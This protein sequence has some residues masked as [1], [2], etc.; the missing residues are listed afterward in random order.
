MSVVACVIIAVAVFLASCMQASIGFGMGMLAAPVVALVAPTLLP[1]MLIASATTV[2]LLVVI[3]ER[4]SL[5]LR[6]TGW[7]LI[8]RVPGTIAG[9]LLLVWLPTRGLSLLLAAV[10]LGGVAVASVGWRPAPGRRNLATAGAASGLLGTATSIGG[11]PMAL[12][13]S[14][15]ESAH[16]RSNMSAFFLAGSL[17][18]LAALAATGSL[19]AEILWAFVALTPV[20]VLGFVA[21]RLVNRLLDRNRLRMVSITVSGIG[22]VLLIGQQLFF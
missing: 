16:V 5:D 13:Y 19:R 15:K 18:S 20:V 21:S 12:V 4:G 9:A 22:A 6:G 10:V 8:G 2:T 7:A 3:R 1:G 14:G 11:P 17:M